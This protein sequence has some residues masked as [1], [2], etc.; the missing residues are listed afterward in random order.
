MMRPLLLLVHFL[1]LKKNA[2]AKK[3]ISCFP[4]KTPLLQKTRKVSFIV[5]DPIEESYVEPLF[6]T[7]FVFK[8]IC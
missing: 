6:P 3:W 1:G 7:K 8:N 2:L 5:I 4:L